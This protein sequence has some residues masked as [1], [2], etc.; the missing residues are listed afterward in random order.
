[1]T[2]SLLSVDHAQIA[3]W[4]R[5]LGIIRTLERRPEIL[6]KANLTLEERQL[7]NRLLTSPYARRYRGSSW[8]NP[9]T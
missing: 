9:P 6:D 7:V 2:E 8:L 5:E 4:R 3:M 1:M